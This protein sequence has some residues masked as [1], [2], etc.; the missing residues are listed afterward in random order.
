MTFGG[1]GVLSILY[2]LLV[3]RP[4]DQVRD[5]VDHLMYLK[6]VFLGYLRQLH[7]TDQ[8]FTR[9]LLDEERLPAAEV[10][11]FAEMVGVT[12]AGAIAQLSSRA[13]S[14]R[15]DVAGAQEKRSRACKP[16]RRLWHVGRSRRCSVGELKQIRV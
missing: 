10:R 15:G 13:T 12:M 5:A 4:R 14:R 11:E 2:T 8:A 6:V 16:S 3:A 7:Q 9:R 1:A